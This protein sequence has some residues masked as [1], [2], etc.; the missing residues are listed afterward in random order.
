MQVVCTLGLVGHA[1]LAGHVLHA[2]ADQAL[3]LRVQLERALQGPASALAGVVVGR[4]ANATTG[5]HHIRAGQGAGQRGRD[6]FRVVPHIVGP[7][8]AQAPACQQLDH[9]GHV[10]VGALAR[11]DLVANDDEPENRRLGLRGRFMIHVDGP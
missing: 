7:A 2:L 3:G 1:L 5:E 9:L 8:Q 4:G 10:L 11:K 6:A